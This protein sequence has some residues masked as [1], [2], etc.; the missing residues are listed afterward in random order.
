MED[1][2]KVQTTEEFPEYGPGPANITPDVDSWKY[3]PSYMKLMDYFQISSDE[4]YLFKDKLETA[5]TLKFHSLVG[6]LP[7]P[8]CN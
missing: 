8:N 4:G 5:S 2:Q 3:D 6:W 7:F 1:A